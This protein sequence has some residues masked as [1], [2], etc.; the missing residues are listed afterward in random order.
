MAKLLEKNGAEM[1]APLA[2][3][4]L[5][6]KRFMEDPEFDK[7]WKEGMTHEEAEV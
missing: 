7:A 6:L 2:V 5:P 1:M 3:I 4:A